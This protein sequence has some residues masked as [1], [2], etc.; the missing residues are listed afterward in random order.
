MLEGTQRGQMTHMSKGV[1]RLDR[2]AAGV[3]E[4]DTEVCTTKS[5]KVLGTNKLWGMAEEGVWITEVER[6][7]WVK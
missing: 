2:E 6:V 1:R 5:G 7:H 3:R 4:W